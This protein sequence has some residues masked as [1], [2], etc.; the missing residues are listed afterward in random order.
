AK[1]IQAVWAQSGSDSMDLLLR[2]SREAIEA[3]KWDQARAHIA[4]LTRLAPDFAEGW[5]ASA[6]YHYLREDYWSAAQ[7]IERVLA[8]EPRH[9]SAMTGLA[10][11]LERTEQDA[12]ALAAWREVQ[13]LYPAFEN[14]EK[15]IERLAPEVDGREL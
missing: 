10:L 2:R 5:N 13:R 4:A 15:A 14:A 1:Q 8:L 7:D 12:G 9:F 11:I 3:E 6:T